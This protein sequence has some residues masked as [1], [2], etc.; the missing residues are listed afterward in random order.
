MLLSKA[1]QKRTVRSVLIVP[2]VS[3]N[4]WIIQKVGSPYQNNKSKNKTFY[5]SS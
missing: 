5:L 4:P 3:S 1:H 2:M